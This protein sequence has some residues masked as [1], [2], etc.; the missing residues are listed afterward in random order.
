MG[1]RSIQLTFC[2]DH[3]DVLFVHVNHSFLSQFYCQGDRTG[4]ISFSGRPIW[5]PWVEPG[6]L[7]P[8]LSIEN[9]FVVYQHVISL[10][11]NIAVFFIVQCKSSESI[12]VMWYSG[13]SD[14]ITGS[15]R[16]GGYFIIVIIIPICCMSKLVK[17]CK[18]LT[19]VS[20]FS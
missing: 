9:L 2:V 5:W 20:L 13:R 19:N 1:R 7:P 10:C 6:G 4:G 8:Q 18:I 17:E 15:S 14:S 16:R 3:A 12:D 11:D